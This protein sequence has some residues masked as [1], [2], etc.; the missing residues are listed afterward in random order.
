MEIVYE[1]ERVLAVAKPAGQEVIPGRGE[2]GPLP[3]LVEEASARCGRKLFV[4]HRLDRDASGVVLLA[5]DAET[6][7]L[8]SM[9]FERRRVAK[10]YLAVVEGI[11]KGSGSVERPLREFG[12]GRIGVAEEG[13]PAA[14]RWRALRA[15]KGATLLE[16]E[17]LTGRRHQIRAHLYSL[18]HPILGDR[19]YGEK[20]P[21]GGA[22]RLML[23]ALSLSIEGPA[24]ARLD[25]RAEP[26]ADFTAVVDSLAAGAPE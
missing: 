11:L 25:P 1:D 22:P 15:L 16:V 20:R 3:P 19:R 21:V 9:A 5:K 12:S 2:K 26:P 7:R 24:G 14:T 6:H 17:P 10:K 8:L 18:G 23:H 4:V 13:K